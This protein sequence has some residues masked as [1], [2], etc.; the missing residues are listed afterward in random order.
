MDHDPA[1]SGSL[2]AQR[3]LNAEKSRLQFEDT[4]AHIE[5]AV[6]VPGCD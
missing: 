2:W 1:R 4:R 5:P 3:D 6:W